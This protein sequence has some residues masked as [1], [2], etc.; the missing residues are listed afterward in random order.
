MTAPRHTSERHGPRPLS[1]APQIGKGA[2]AA[3][4]TIAAFT[5]KTADE[6]EAIAIVRAH[7]RTTTKRKPKS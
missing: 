4:A 7:N 1:V 2:K 3:F 6:H 5:G